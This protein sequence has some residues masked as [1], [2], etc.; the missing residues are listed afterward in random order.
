MG[1]SQFKLVYSFLGTASV[2]M[3]ITET[4]DRVHTGA[5]IEL[6]IVIDIFC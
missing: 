5:V 6:F 1:L 4:G 3:V 2:V